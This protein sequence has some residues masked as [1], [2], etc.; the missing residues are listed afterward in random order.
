MSVE[1]LITDDELNRLAR[2]L[3]LA[4][5]FVREP[6][7]SL[8]DDAPRLSARVGVGPL[9][10]PLTARIESFGVTP[11]HRLAVRLR[12]AVA[13]ALLRGLLGSDRDAVVYWET[14][15]GCVVLDAPRLAP[16][17]RLMGVTVMGRTLRFTGALRWGR[18]AGSS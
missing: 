6:S 8:A 15:G 14:D 1:I 4:P 12:G 7:L 5:R 17:L 9:A 18:R 11:E 16:W 10:L 13:T 3:H 2:S